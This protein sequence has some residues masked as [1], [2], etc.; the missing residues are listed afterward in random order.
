METLSGIPLHSD[1]E[2]QTRRLIVVNKT[3]DKE[4]RNHIDYINLNT[5]PQVHPPV[6]SPASLHQVL[7]RETMSDNGTDH[8]TPYM[9]ETPYLAEHQLNE[10][11]RPTM[12]DTLDGGKGALDMYAGHQ[13]YV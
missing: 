5:P 8:G 10:V 11:G 4:R 6:H 12:Y 1:D 9:A 13:W 2:P 3:P 7:E